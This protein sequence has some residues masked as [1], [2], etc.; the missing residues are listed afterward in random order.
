[1]RA[2]EGDLIRT[3]D[4]VIFDVKGLIH[5][6]NKVVAFPRYLPSAEGTRGQAGKLYTKVYNLNERYQ[7]LQKNTPNLLVDDPV[8]GEKLCEVPTDQIAQHY[9]PIEKLQELRG[10]QKLQ[11]LEQKV[12]SWRRNLSG[13]PT[14]LV[15]H[16]P[17]LAPSWR[18]V[19]F[20]K[21]T[22][23]PRLRRG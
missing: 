16:R 22:S 7:Y 23:T 3:S 4:N 19:Y 10:A 13:Q 17:S 1:M 20:C 12:V 18:G 21:A 8:F 11:P 5:P 15:Q 14:F 9:D 2:R 6:P